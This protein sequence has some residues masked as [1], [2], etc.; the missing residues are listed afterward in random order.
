MKESQL[1]FYFDCNAQHTWKL[2]CRLTNE[3][4]RYLTQRGEH[5]PNAFFVVL[6]RLRQG[7]FSTYNIQTTFGANQIPSP[8]TSIYKLGVPLRHAGANG[9]RKYSSYSFLTSALDGS[10]QRHV[11]SALYPRGKDPDT[12]G[13]GG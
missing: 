8:L 7:F 1:Y 9:E 6:S 13:I 4:W 5:F 11:P 10:A 12:H 3:E 2:D